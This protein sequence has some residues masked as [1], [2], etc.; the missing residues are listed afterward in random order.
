M[1]AFK[2]T[3]EI[4]TV[5]F[6]VEW[7]LFPQKQ[8]VLWLQ[9]RRRNTLKRWSTLGRSRALSCISFAEPC[10]LSQLMFSIPKLSKKVKRKIK[11]P[12]KTQAQTLWVIWND[13]SYSI[14]LF[15]SHLIPY[16]LCILRGWESLWEDHQ[17]I[18]SLSNFRTYWSAV[19]ASLFLG[20][21]FSPFFMRCTSQ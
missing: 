4:G 3:Q 14:G 19:L 17:F 16:F 7:Y 1:P 9:A 21:L 18:D 6:L 8:S 5:S 13:L 2:N 10:I 11:I 15:I 12:L 20:P